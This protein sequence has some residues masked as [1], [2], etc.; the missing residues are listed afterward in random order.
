MKE[1]ATYHH[2]QLRK[3]LLKAAL[4]ELKQHGAADLSLRRIAALA[5][6]SHAAPYRHFR[7]KQEILA[8]LVW[9]AQE[10]FTTAL[11]T[12]RES[13]GAPAAR[14]FAIGE[15]Y[16]RFAR[17]NPERLTL[18]FSEAGIAAM[19]CYPVELTADAL[20]RY[21][22]FGVLEDTVKECQEAGIL[23][24]AGDSGALSILV[25][26]TVHGLSVIEREGFLASL[27]SQ[28]GL[29]VEEAHGLVMKEFRKLVERGAP[30]AQRER[31][32]RTTTRR[33]RP[34]PPSDT[35]PA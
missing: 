33:P 19:N 3:A 15:A 6:V 18:M 22:S 14:L 2:P 10:A 20:Q 9:D 1:K 32:A 29:G 4:V 31:G 23:S 8:A 21:N 25:W 27:G 35:P 7:N 26:S 5:N 30:A 34:A 16:L 28:R 12:A 11:R 17:D 13:A 24:G